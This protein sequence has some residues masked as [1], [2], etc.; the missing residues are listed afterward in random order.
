MSDFKEE[1]EKIRELIATEVELD[2]LKVFFKSYKFPEEK[3]LLH[4]DFL[5]DYNDWIKEKNNAQQLSNLLRKVA[6]SIENAYKE[7]LSEEN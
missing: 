2:L 5:K 4:I 3:E 6:D 1:A 7:E